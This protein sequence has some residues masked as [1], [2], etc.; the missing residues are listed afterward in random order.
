MSPTNDNRKE[1]IAL[2][3]FLGNGSAFNPFLNDTGAYFK[4]GKT[5]FMIDCGSS[6]FKAALRKNIFEEIKRVC[7]VITHLH[8]DHC[9]SLSQLIMYLL[10]KKCVKPLIIFPNEEIKELLRIT[11]VTEDMYD[12]I[13]DREVV[14]SGGVCIRF[15]DST[16]VDKIKCYS[17]EIENL[18]GANIYY[19]GDSGE[20]P[21]QILEKYL[22]G[23]YD[24]FF[25]DTCGEY[26]PGK[27]HLNIEVLCR[28]IPIG[29]RNRLYCIHL[30]T[31]LNKNMI[32]EKGFNT[33]NI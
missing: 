9:G 32:I 14:I 3:K 16:H 26:I 30:D 8:M 31:L 27:V 20:I 17:I 22:S 29:K 15:I 18:N 21:S 4:I 11:G 33:V 25:Q 13:S 10:Y 12:Y 1:C 28:L 7:V 23:E 6:V 19:S 5:L 2:L 24:A